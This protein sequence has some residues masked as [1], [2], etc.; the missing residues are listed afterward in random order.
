MTHLSWDGETIS[1]PLAWAMARG[2]EMVIFRGGRIV[3]REGRRE[4]DFVEGELPASLF[5][6]FKA[7]HE[8]WTFV[9]I[10]RY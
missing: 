5:D 4:P 8:G 10:A 9:E 3:E 6:E 2:E 1:D 7:S